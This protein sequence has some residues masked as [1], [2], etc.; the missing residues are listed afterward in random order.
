M[1]HPTGDAL[2]AAAESPAG[3]PDDWKQVLRDTPSAGIEAAWG[4]IANAW[5][6]DWTQA[7][8]DWREAAERWRDRNI[9]FISPEEQKQGEEVLRAIDERDTQARARRDGMRAAGIPVFGPE[10]G[11]AAEKMRERYDEAKRQAECLHDG[12]TFIAGAFVCC[13][14]CGKPLQTVPPM[15]AEV[16]A[17]AARQA[18]REIDRQ[19]PLVVRH[20]IR[21]GWD[22]PNARD[23][24][25][26]WHERLAWRY[27]RRL[28]RG[29][30]RAVVNRAHERSFLVSRSYHEL[31]ALI[32]RVFD[33]E[34][35]DGPD[36]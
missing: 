26:R 23:G 30:V 19:D 32:D 3:P 11:T 18:K 12:E 10:P 5:G 1:S 28:I 2:P 36:E 20:C 27:C 15:I 25:L 17:E 31:H 6:G 33:A 4:I 14:E 7:P 22:G 35:I 21:N 34:T 16:R 8:A 9:V 24:E 29:T 13:K